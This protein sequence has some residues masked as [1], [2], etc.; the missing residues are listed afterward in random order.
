MERFGKRS[1]CGRGPR[2]ARGVRPSNW[3]R[4]TPASIISVGHDVPA[5]EF[6]ILHIIAILAQLA[7]ETASASLDQKNWIFAP[8]RNEQ[9]RR[10]SR[11][12]RRQSRAKTPV[13]QD[14]RFRLR[15]NAG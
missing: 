2:S 13:C 10:I 15:S 4:P 11:S 14:S 1:H 7:G 9:T 6:A 5:A 12:D 3:R 8:M